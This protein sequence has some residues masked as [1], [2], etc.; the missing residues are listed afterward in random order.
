VT[1]SDEDDYIELLI[2]AAWKTTEKVLGRPLK[3]IT[4]KQYFDEFPGKDFVLL[5]GNVTS[6][7]HIKY[8]DADNALQTFTDFT[9][10]KIMDRA[11][12]RLT[13][14][15]TIYDR[16]NCI[17]IQYVCSYTV[18]ADVIAAMKLMIGE[19]YEKRENTVKRMPTAADH[20]LSMNRL[21]EI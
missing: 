17:E 19:M 12:I 20:I 18:P 13:T 10:D 2:N 16:M 5:W 15:P 7:T 4:V 1:G 11:R 14:E 6:V 9:T 3:Q 21:W 8:Y